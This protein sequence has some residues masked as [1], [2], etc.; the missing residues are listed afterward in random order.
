M[1]P[2]DDDI[3]SYVISGISNKLHCLILSYEST[4]AVD[5]SM[6]Q[7]DDHISRVY[8]KTGNISVRLRC[9]MKNTH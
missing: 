5:V 1:I 8:S 9:W 3:S 7:V 2:S 6:V 4:N